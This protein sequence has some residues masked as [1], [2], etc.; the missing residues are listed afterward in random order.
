VDEILF[1]LLN[2]T[3]FSQESHTLCQPCP[4]LRL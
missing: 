3:R 1:D 4:P 2:Y